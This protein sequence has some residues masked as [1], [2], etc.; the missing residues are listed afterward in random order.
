M[1]CTFECPVHNRLKNAVNIVVDSAMCSEVLHHISS[2]FMDQWSKLQHL[3]GN[4]L[5][6]GLA[7][8]C[9]PFF[10]ISMKQRTIFLL[11]HAPNSSYAWAS[12]SCAKPGP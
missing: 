3:P 11:S 2:Y 1:Q 4:N 5:L 7:A 6:V 12:Q 9:M 8:E 10:Q